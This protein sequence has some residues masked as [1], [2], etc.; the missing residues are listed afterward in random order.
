MRREC[1]ERYPRHCGLAI[2]TCIT[3][4]AWRTCCDA[5]RDRYLAVSLGV[6]DGENVPDIPGACTTRNFTY[7][8]RGPWSISMPHQT[9]WSFWPAPWLPG[10]ATWLPWYIIKTNRSIITLRPRQNG[11]H[12]ADDTFKYIFL[13]ENVIIS[14]K[15]S[16][17]FVPKGSINNI[18]TLVQIMAWR[19]PGDKP[20]SEPMMVRYLDYR[21]I[22][23]SLGLN[24]LFYDAE[25]YFAMHVCVKQA[26][27]M[28][29]FY[30]PN[31]FV[32]RS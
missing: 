7:L 2:P 31:Y 15:I 9:G 3:A 4:R 6:G 25:V 13:N 8:V 22:Y 24:E 20:L 17:K 12:F 27:K 19:R 11:R 5:C 18:P 30:I 10:K 29:H 1:R 23:A 32:A 28:L 16:L 21:R 14:A 26:R